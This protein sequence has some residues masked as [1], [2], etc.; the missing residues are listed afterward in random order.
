MSRITPLTAAVLAVLAAACAGLPSLGDPDLD[1]LEPGGEPLAISRLEQQ[2]P[3][4][5]SGMGQ[6]ERTVVDDQMEW[7]QVWSRLWHNTQPRPYAPVVDFAREL[8]IVAAMG[9]RPTGGYTIQVDEARTY[10]DHVTV[11]AIETSPGRTCVTTQAFTAPVDVVKIPRTSLP[12]RF[13]TTKRVHE[14]N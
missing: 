11:H 14:C 3:I 4:L 7:E 1:E 9:A 6:A 8:V 5:Y 10:A 13:R 2:P 12:I